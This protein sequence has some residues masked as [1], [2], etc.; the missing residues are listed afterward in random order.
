[1]GCEVLTALNITITV[2]WD[3]MPRAVVDS[4]E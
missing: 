3:V 1:M 4:L 2:L